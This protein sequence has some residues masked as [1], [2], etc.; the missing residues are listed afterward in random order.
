MHHF[1]VTPEQVKEKQIWIEGSDVNHIKNVLRMKIGEEL[2]ISDGNNQKYLCE[3]SAISSDEVCVYQRGI[4]FRYR[5]TIKDL[6]VPGTSK[7]R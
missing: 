6:S 7:E 3:I 1:F 5:I 4:D 2:H